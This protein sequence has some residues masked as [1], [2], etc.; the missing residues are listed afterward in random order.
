VLT[1]SADRDQV[2]R[3]VAS[4][5]LACPGCGGR[6]AGWGRARERRIRR[7]DGR[8]VRLTP[9]RARCRDC[10]RTHVLLPV[11]CLA[12]RADEAAVIGAA[13]E[14][15]AAGAGHR[16]IAL[17]LGRPPST[18]RGWLRAFAARAE[19]VRQAF[20]VLAAGLVTDPPL[21]GPAGA[22]LSD[23]VAAVAAAA[24]AAARFLGVGEVT[25]W[26]LAAAVTSGMLL[27]PSR[28]AG[29]INASWPWAL[30]G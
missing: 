15:K 14:A 28:A 12:R 23:A 17:L 27:A 6:L 1:V 10:G 7:L 21:P 18:V 11:T 30:G 29:M 4:G 20:T 5:G 3:Q 13:L 19:L 2:E 24:V 16:T 26:H 22:V 8:L 25:R 9:R